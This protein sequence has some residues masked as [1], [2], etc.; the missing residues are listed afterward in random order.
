MLEDLKGKN[1]IIIT[2]FAYSE[3]R[4]AEIMGRVI[5]VE[6]DFIK[7]D[8]KSYKCFLGIGLKS[9]KT[10]PCIINKN[11]IISIFEK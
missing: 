2:S 9:D 10:G 5:D 6:D 7:L 3:A 8:L 1:V 4:N 11:Y